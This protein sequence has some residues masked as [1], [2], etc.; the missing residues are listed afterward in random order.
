MPGAHQD[1]RWPPNSHVPKKINTGCPPRCHVPTKRPHAHQKKGWVLTMLLVLSK[2]HA[3][4]PARCQ[5]TPKMPGAQKKKHWVPM[6]MLGGQLNVT[7]PPK[8]TL[9]AH[10][11]ARWPRKRRVSTKSRPVA[12]QHARWAPERQMT[13]KMK[14]GA[15]QYAMCPT[16]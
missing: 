6:K 7:C 13:T 5:V 9:C 1:A 10:I 8:E 16:K 14:A 15:H 4:C 11:D 12:C 2:I 3:G